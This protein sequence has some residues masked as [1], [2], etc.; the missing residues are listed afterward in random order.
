MDFKSAMIC[1]VAYRHG[2]WLM[3]FLYDALR[4]SVI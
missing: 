3:L 1:K 4:E 2:R